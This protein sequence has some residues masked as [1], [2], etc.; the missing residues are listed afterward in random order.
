M[1]AAKQVVPHYYLSV[2]L[3]LSKLLDMRSQL[4][5]DNKD[6]TSKVSVLDLIVKAVGLAV[7]QVPDVN[8]S[9][10]D[11]FVRRYSQVDVN[12]VMG[13]GSTVLTPVIRD[14]NG[15]GLRAIGKEMAEFEEM[16]FNNNGEPVDG[17]KIA[18]GTISV[19]DLG[20]YGVKSAAPIVLPPQSCALALGTI[21]DTVVPA[22]GGKDKDWAV[23]PVVVATLSCDHRVIDGAVGAQYLSA[24]KLLV[25]NPVALIL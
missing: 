7:K 15:K 25:E 24:L 6:S 20:M 17:S 1:T 10:N 8:A 2:E 3:N 4:N 16:A 19:H 18:I 12:L 11:T 9:W 21:V 13:V 22:S 14:V 23:A 5:A